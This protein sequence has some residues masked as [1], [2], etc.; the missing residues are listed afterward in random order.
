MS[1]HSLP[2]GKAAIEALAQLGEALG[3][4][5][6]LERPVEEDR[7]N[8]PAVDVAWLAEPG[9]R[10]PLMIFE[11]ESRE[12]NAAANNP[13]K[14]FGQSSRE[15]EKPLFFFHV[16][17][18]TGAA[19]TRAD[20]L[21]SLFGAYN[22]RTYRLDRQGQKPLLLDILSQHRRLHKELRLGALLDHLD[23]GS[24]EVPLPEVLEHIEGLAFSASY[25]NEYAKRGIANPLYRQAFARLLAKVGLDKAHEVAGYDTYLGHTWPRPIHIGILAFSSPVASDWLEQLRWWQ[26][27]WAYMSMIGPHFGQSRDYDGFVLG[28]SPVLWA[29]TAALMH[30]VP[31][32]GHYIGSQVKL[33]LDEIS[34]APPEVCFFTA[35]WLLHIASA[36]QDAEL[37]DSARSTI[38]KH[39]G[40][41]QGV[42]YQPPSVADVI[43]QEDNWSSEL[44]AGPLLDVP[45]ML[46][47]QH[48]QSIRYTADASLETKLHSAAFSALTDVMGAYRWADDVAH[49]LYLSRGAKTPAAV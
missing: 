19:S 37:Y 29:L 17:V 48:R 23:L 8:P 34:E 42:L 14:V 25:L 24:W 31:G 1:E 28:H 12:T 40:I 6:E 49:S 21:E 18:Q 7:P 30:Q 22:Y 46:E 44:S 20:R 2:K 27:E 45:P 5:I 39:G 36:S 13:V 47:F 16:F 4:E 3:Y 11:V 15:F 10:Y 38:N 43:D 33:V 26:E 32:A 35:V 41:G 9:Q